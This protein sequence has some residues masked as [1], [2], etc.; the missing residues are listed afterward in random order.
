MENTGNPL[1]TLVTVNYNGLE[2]TRAFLDSLKKVSYKPIEIIVVD[3]ASPN[4]VANLD[5]EYPEIKLIKSKEN[6]GFAGGNNLGIREGKGKYFFLLNNDTECE[7]GFLEPMVELMESNP[8]IGIGSSRLIYYSQPDTL[9]YAGS[10]GINPYTGRGFAIGHGEKDNPEFHKS[11]QTQLAHGAAMMISR[12]ALEKVGMMAD[13]FFLYYEEVDFCERVKRGG[14]EIW[15]CGA[16]LVLH[17][18]SMSVGKE[19]PMK[20]YYLTRNRLM[21]TRRNTRGLQ[22]ILAV[23]FFYFFA[24]PKGILTYLKRKEF[25]LLASFWRG[26]IWN[27]FNHQIFY[28]E[29]LILK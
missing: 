25:K 9:Q 10:T 18:E 17:K 12:A 22:R 2:H 28:N 5:Q 19:S 26:A 21:Y 3:N 7:P 27:L 29:G 20:V 16:S 24:F 1:V 4:G 13:L 8:K 6:L 11:Y 15:Y 23:C 14:F